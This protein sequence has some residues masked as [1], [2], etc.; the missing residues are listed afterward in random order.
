M[1]EGFGLVREWMKSKWLELR[2]GL[3]KKEGGMGVCF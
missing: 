1:K 2:G 3:V